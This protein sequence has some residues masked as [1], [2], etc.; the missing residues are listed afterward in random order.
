[1]PC[2]VLTGQVI[3]FHQHHV[4]VVV[5][6]PFVIACFLMRVCLLV[7]RVGLVDLKLFLLADV[8]D[9]VL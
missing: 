9:G 2:C 1:M 4:I 7:G 6:S 8:S 5:H 3:L